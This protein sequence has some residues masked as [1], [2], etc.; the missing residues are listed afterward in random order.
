VGK[1]IIYYAACIL[2]ALSAYSDQSSMSDFRIFTA[3]DGRVIEA[4][5]IACE[6]ARGK[7]QIERSN[8]KKVW[9]QADIFSE[10]DQ[11]YIRDWITT[12]R[13]LSNSK[14]RISVEKQKGKKS[15]NGTPIYYELTLDNR[16]RTSLENLNV[17]YRIMVEE[18]G[19]SHRTDSERSVAGHVKFDVLPAGQSIKKKTENVLL[20]LKY[21][22]QTETTYYSDGSSDTD[23]SK[24][25]VREDKAAGIWLKIQGPELDGNPVIREFI[26]PSDLNKKYSWDAL[27]AIGS[28]SK[29]RGSSGSIS[30]EKQSKARKLRVQANESVRAK[31][32]T[33]AIELYKQAYEE[34]KGPSDAWWV[35][36]LYLWYEP[37]KNYKLAREWYDIAIEQ[38]YYR[39]HYDLAEYYYRG[40]DQAARDGEKAVYH[41]EMAAKLNKKDSVTHRIL[42]SAYAYNEQFR[43][44]VKAQEKAV[45]FYGKPP[46]SETYFNKLKT[47]LEEYKRKAL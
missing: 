44:A 32:I 17:D 13:F 3:A 6:P 15:S 29:N 5:I 25:K 35:G 27:V 16:T 36:R 10:E 8:R 28:S 4:K 18:K 19:Y 22:T 26:Y 40:Y 43:Q 34:G 33:K 31:E 24:N 37:Y 41:A 9:V 42:A 12:D 30:G 2:I 38:K 11:N 14:F 47:T 23:T 45:E 39:A 46:K 20:V 21:T 7:V 1:W